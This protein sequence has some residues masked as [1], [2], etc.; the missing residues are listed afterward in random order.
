[1]ILVSGCSWSDSNFKSYFH[2]DMDCSYPKWFDMIDTDEKV[3][4]IGMSG[5]SNQT[6]IDRALKQVH[7]NPDISTVVIALTEW[8]RF[9]LMN[10][11]INP[12]LLI[13]KANLEKKT[14][15]AEKDKLNYKQ[16]IDW[17]KYHEE[18]VKVSNMNPREFI[19]YIVDDT[20]FKLKT[21]QDVCKLKGIKLYVFQMLWPMPH[22]YLDLGIKTLIK[23]SVFQEMFENPDINFLNFPFFRELGGSSFEATMKEREDYQS[24][25]VSFVDKHPN[26][27]GHRIIAEWFNEQ[28][29]VS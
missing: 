26:E 25:V 23:N 9:S 8:P 4:S 6:M 21:L 19:P 16:I 11:E 2:V 27:K 15:W 18:Y 14:E 17:L 13:V 24:L 28:I 10:F 22:E 7:I 29:K 1:M 12:S 20:I 3:V 5:W